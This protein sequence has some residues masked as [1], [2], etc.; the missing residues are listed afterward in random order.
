MHYNPIYLDSWLSKLAVDPCT[1]RKIR[2]YIRERGFRRRA[3]S[4]GAFDRR[5]AAERKHQRHGLK[6]IVEFVG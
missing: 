1:V 2:T 4:S 6:T 5:V 3:K